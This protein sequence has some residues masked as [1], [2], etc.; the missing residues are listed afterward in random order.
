MG[1]A[2]GW[3]ALAVTAVSAA[4][5]AGRSGV[6]IKYT[7][8]FVEAEGLGWRDAVFTRLT[9][10]TRQGAA[11]VWTAPSDVAKRLVQHATK[12]SAG[13]VL[14]AP[15]VTVWSGLPAHI[16]TRANRQL[17]TQVAWN[18]DEHSVQAKPETV[19]TGTATT[20]T[21]RKLDQGILVQIVLQD[22]QILAVH[23][24]ALG[25]R[26]G[27]NALGVVKSV[28]YARA[29]CDSQRT[30]EAAQCDDK[31]MADSHDPCPVPR[32]VMELVK[33][34]ERARM[35]A[36][37]IDLAPE[38]A[39]DVIAASVP[40][41]ECCSPTTTCPACSKDSDARKVAVEVPEIGSQEIAGEWLIPKD[42]ILLMSFG[43]HTVADGGGKAIIRERLAIVEAEEATAPIGL[44]SPHQCVW[45][46]SSYNVPVLPFPS[47]TSPA[48]ASAAPAL[49][50]PAGPPEMPMPPMPPVP[51]RSMPQGY[52]RDGTAAELPPLP[53][54]DADDDNASD[55]AEPRPSLQSKK[56]QQPGPATDAKPEPV[57]PAADSA[58]KKAQY[59]APSFPPL[60]T[61]FQP[62]PMV[63]LQFL[64]PIRPVSFRLPFNRRLELEIYGRVVRS[65]EPTSSTDVVAKPGNGDKTTK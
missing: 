14:Q 45:P 21:G 63:G 62:A 35:R 47:A 24:V 26:D 29:Q 6:P 25:D 32:R 53:D 54:D 30:A 8:R 61:L 7:V 52:H 50:L 20:L 5:E 57:R 34:Q 58:M 9:P 31:S 11:T 33:A 13:R 37:G 15:A 40:A 2:L 60:P 59:A 41:P 56:S 10:V 38:S 64:L 1:V 46:V 16:T 42:G 43:P 28:H 44:P 49:N 51:S 4:P 36:M 23:R 22:T 12:N 55:S 39:G 19:R 3:M 18:G 48:P 17:V 27:T 65:P